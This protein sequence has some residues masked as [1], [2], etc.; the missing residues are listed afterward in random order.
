MVMVMDFAGDFLSE[1]L[2]N[3]DEGF[4]ERGIMKLEPTWLQFIEQTVTVFMKYQN[5]TRNTAGP[6]KQSNIFFTLV[7]DSSMTPRCR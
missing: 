6:A 5:K 2:A 4:Y 7:I 1:F 3:R